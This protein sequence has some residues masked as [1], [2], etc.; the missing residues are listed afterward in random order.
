MNGFVIDHL[1]KETVKYAIH[2]SNRSFELCN[3]EMKT[4]LGILI[5]SGY[6]SVPRRRLYWQAELIEL[7]ANSM[8]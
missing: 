5:V 8:F 7:I 2:R 4:F 6:C 1:V 3:T